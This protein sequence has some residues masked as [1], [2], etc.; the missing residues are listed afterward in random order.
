MYLYIKVSCSIIRG[1]PCVQ[2]TDSY[3]CCVY[4]QFVCLMV[5]RCYQMGGAAPPL[6]QPSP[7][8]PLP[9]PPPTP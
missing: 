4:V 9:P 6:V 1:S 2:Y 8:P 5:F 7:L 3:F